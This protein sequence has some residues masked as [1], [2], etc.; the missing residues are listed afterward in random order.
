MASSRT[1]AHRGWLPGPSGKKLPSSEVKEE[2]TEEEKEIGEYQ[3][4]EEEK[5]TFAEEKKEIE[6][7]KQK[8]TIEEGKEAIEKEKESFEVLS[9][10]METE[11]SE[12]EKI[13]DSGV[14][15]EKEERQSLEN[16][17]LI[18]PFPSFIWGDWVWPN[19]YFFISCLYFFFYPTLELLTLFSSESFFLLLRISWLDL[20]WLDLIFLLDL[21]SLLGIQRWW[22][23]KRIHILYE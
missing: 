17:N 5:E 8:Q 11:D 23:R 15:S 7:E 13:N 9:L 20:T 22:M 19:C 12:E 21:T 2:I 4:V 6:K 1:R 18:L 3:T 14:G 16:N 10:N